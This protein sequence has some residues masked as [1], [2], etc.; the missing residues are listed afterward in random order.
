MSRVDT[1][2]RR[3]ADD[4]TECVVVFVPRDGRTEQVWMRGLGRDARRF[5]DQLGPQMAFGAGELQ[6]RAA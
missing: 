3:L 4:E 6:L 5:R 2:Q 1:W